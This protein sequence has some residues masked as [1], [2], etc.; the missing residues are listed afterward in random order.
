MKK[1]VQKI[2]RNIYAGKLLLTAVLFILGSDFQSLFASH[3]VGGELTYRYLGNNRYEIKLVVRRD[4]IN[5]SDTVPFDNPAIIGVFYR[6]NQKAFRVGADGTFRMAQMNNDTLQEKPDNICP[7]PLKEV[8]V[9]QSTYIDT[10]TIPYEQRGYY[11]VYQRCC[12]NSTLTN[13]E[14]A[15]SVGTTFVAEIKPLSADNINS[16]PAFGLEYPPIYTCVNKEMI[17]DH[18]ATDED[19]DSLVYSLCTPYLGKTITFPADRP[20]NPPYTLLN[21]APGF[22]LNNLFGSPATID[23]T[24]GLF[25]VTPGILGQF[26]VGVCV[27]EYR[28][29]EFLSEVRRDFEV[30]VVNCGV[31]P[32][33]K[34]SVK[35]EIC[36]GLEVEFQNES[37]AGLEFT[38][39]F[40]W[41]GDR[42]RQ[43][44]LLNP[45]FTY[46]REGS[47]R[48]VLAVKNVTCV[49]TFEQVIRVID[50]QLKPDFSYELVCD[51][52]G[53]LK[54]ID[55][56]QSR[57]QIIE[58]SW[59]IFG[60][61]D[62]IRSNE[63]NPVITIPKEGFYE[64]TLKIR[65]TFG[66]YSE[67]IKDINFK[68]VDAELIGNEASI[69]KGDSIRL[70]K[71]AKPGLVF[72]WSP[73]NS[74]NLSNPANPW[75]KPFTTTV[76]TVTITDG[77]CQVIK[78]IEIKVKERIKLSVTGDSIN[79]NGFV[80]LK[81]H[82][83]STNL[84]YWYTDP[85][86]TQL[87]SQDSILLDTIMQDTRYYVIAG[88]ASE[89]CPDTTSILVKYKAFNVEFNGDYQICAGDSLV[90]EI[91]PTGTKDTLR[92]IWDNNPILTGPLNSLTTKVYV[93][94]PGRY[95][96]RF[97]IKN[98]YDCEVEDSIIITAIDHP[99]PEILA[100]SECGSLKIKYSTNTIGRVFWDFGDGT[101]TSTAKSGD[102]VYPKPGRYIIRLKSDTICSREVETEV[103]V[104]EL[105]INLKDT[106]ISC[107]GESVFLNPGGDPKYHYEW[108]PV[109]GLD[110][111]NS[112][113]P[114]ATISISKWYYV[115]VTDQDFPD[116]CALFD[117]IFVLVPPF[118]ESHAT[119]DTFLCE[120]AK[121]NLS[122]SSNLT[123]VKYIWCDEKNN[124]LGDKPV[125]EVEIGETSRFILKVTD[126]YGCTDRDT[127]EVILYELQATIK[128]DDKICV[129]D[130]AMLS[131]QVQ[132]PGMYMYL[133]EPANFIIGNPMDSIVKVYTEKTQE[134]KVTINNKLGCEWS[135]THLL[136]IND[137]QL[138]LVVDAQ[139]KIVVGGQTSQLMATFNPNWTYLWSPDDGSLNDIRI[140]N[141]IATP[142]KTTTYTVVVTD[143]AGCTASASVTIV[144]QSCIDAVFLPNAFSP[145]NDSK[146][147]QLCVRTRPGTV[148]KMELLIYSRWGEKIFQ[149]TDPVFCWD[150]TY[151]NKKLSPDVFGYILRFSCLGQEE[152]VKKG[153]IS[154]LK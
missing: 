47:Y 127:I 22:G 121:I 141:P 55:S 44:T 12:R 118:V 133:W 63:K 88:S 20:D 40:D 33:A 125:I 83:D 79:C 129:N 14:H 50:P 148:S 122:G 43:S 120:K 153:N 41:D 124:T 107:F 42:S 34:F 117:S 18:S 74:L 60:P 89:Q 99:I 102:Y 132:P 71:S 19:G 1:T 111:P 112:P 4:C 35:S 136:T 46:P 61:N 72:N 116:S 62:S 96:L 131:A 84:Y 29:G 45:T 7:G 135:F 39:F 78:Q 73:T 147:E 106:V 53:I 70:V 87:I 38:W 115:K 92:I 103:T 76:Y 150:G 113:N 142:S 11:L 93:S 23:P 110:N 101:G 94:N 67:I 140:H 31:Q 27:K 17:F 24:T 8:C 69:C 30:N 104:V 105:K 77:G 108:T 48:V 119:P 16:T 128:G 144:V 56:S 37:V 151:K 13:I 86:F 5:G 32:T 95:V 75:A 145:N 10:F 51:T 143:E 15:D 152:Q 138:S 109:E 137:P 28:N 91:K 139:P 36:K 130:T 149:S 90:I 66:C 57:Y 98:Q 54:L 26:L 80:R 85:G 146:N 52:I 21:W 65:D 126:R 123:D 64:I 25:K 59:C 68:F 3:I 114:K 49:D 82:A 100:E 2:F 6:D 81:A 154:L 58:T 134:F 9:H 97:H